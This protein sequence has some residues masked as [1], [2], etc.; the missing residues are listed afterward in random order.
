M[1]SNSPFNM[2]KSDLED[3]DEDDLTDISVSSVRQISENLET[4]DIIEFNNK[5][6]A[7]FTFVNIFGLDDTW[8]VQAYPG[9]HALNEY[10]G[11]LLG[12]ISIHPKFTLVRAMDRMES[13][14]DL[15]PKF[16]NKR[17]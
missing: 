11:V 1:R 14:D 4:A 17:R 12:R 16:V 15:P 13:G 3:V 5:D 2:D 10:D 9:T 8:T 7:P 6:M